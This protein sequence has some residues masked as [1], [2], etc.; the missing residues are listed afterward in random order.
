MESIP[1]TIGWAAVGLTLVLT[2]WPKAGL[3]ARWRASRR[4]S[5]RERLE[6][7]LKV[8][9]DHEQA[10]RHASTE[11]LASALG[12]RA[13]ATQALIVTLERQGLTERREGGLHLSPDGERL[14][15][16]VVRAHRLW[17]RYLAG[18]ARLPLEKV[19]RE[20]HRLEHRLTPAEVDALDA[21]LGHPERDPHGDPI[22]GRDGTL[23]D[24]R[25]TPLPEWP[26]DA[27]GVILH[28]EDEPPLAY[29]QLLAEGLRLGQRVRI[30]ERGPLRVVLSDGER[31]YRLAP[32]VAANLTLAPASETPQAQPGVVSLADLPD[33]IPAQVVAIDGR[34]QGYTRRRLLDLGMTPGAQL[35]PEMRNFS[36]DPRAYR[37]RG[38]LIALR[39]EQAD[40]IWVRPIESA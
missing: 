19:H 13:S 32:A 33:R 37:I 7:A 29:A 4:T 1:M 21:Q 25:G 12:L 8:L 11:A 23:P 17:E 28:I 35:Q 40:Q 6:D 30:L 31:E 5:R 24:D 2:L 16:Q 27:P 15:M 36:G 39:R 26:V 10:G 22:P 3:V 38:T 9:L 20:A 34:L 14:A 18:E